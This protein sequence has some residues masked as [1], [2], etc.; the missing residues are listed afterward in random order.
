VIWVTETTLRKEEEDDRSRGMLDLANNED[1]FVVLNDDSV[2]VFTVFFSRR[3]EWK[4][5][6]DKS[7][8]GY[9][10]WFKESEIDENN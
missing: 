5:N 4:N 1:E 6:W 2:K 3:D 7:I 9:I 8:V 10:W